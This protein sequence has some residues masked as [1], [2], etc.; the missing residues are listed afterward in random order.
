MRT[1]RHTGRQTGYRHDNTNSA[2]R[3]VASATNNGRKLYLFHFSRGCNFMEV[4]APV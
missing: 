3:S 4:A 2:V 1:E